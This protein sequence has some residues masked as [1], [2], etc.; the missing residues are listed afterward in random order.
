[1][2]DPTKNDPNL[3]PAAEVARRLSISVS[4]VWRWSR[5][6]GS[7]FPRPH[8]I[9]HPAGFQTYT[10]WKADELYAWIDSL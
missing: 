1:M 7:S 4:T 8:R 9:R 3:L 10:R 6:E 2:E 5:E